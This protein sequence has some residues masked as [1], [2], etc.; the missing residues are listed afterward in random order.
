MDTW[1]LSLLAFGVMGVMLSMGVPIAFALA[2][3]AI[4]GTLLTWGPRDF[5]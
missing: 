5:T 1:L 4:A 2:G 3:V